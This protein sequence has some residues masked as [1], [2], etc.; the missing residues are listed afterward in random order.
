MANSC[1]C[2][3][4]HKIPDR[5]YISAKP[6]LV[7]FEVVANETHTGNSDSVHPCKHEEFGYH[8]HV[9]RITEH[10]KGNT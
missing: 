9:N 3:A 2:K 1:I 5:Q 6:I 4:V 7:A 10:Y 8:I